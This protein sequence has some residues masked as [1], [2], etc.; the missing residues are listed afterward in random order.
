MS[1]TGYIRLNKLSQDIGV[2]ERTIRGWIRQG[3]TCY[4]PSRRLVLIKRTDL[5][6]FLSKYK[7]DQRQIDDLVDQIIEDV[8]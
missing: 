8:V 1:N 4:R 7:D 3:L 2:C 5:D 6:V